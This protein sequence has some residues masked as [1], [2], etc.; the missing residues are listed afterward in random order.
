MLYQLPA[1]RFTNA[2]WP[3]FRKELKRPWE[4]HNINTVHLLIRSREKYPNLV[5]EEYLTSS[6][7]SPEILAALSF[8]HLSRLFWT[9]K[10]TATVITHPAYD[11]FGEFLA[12]SP[13]SAL[14]FWQNEINE[15]LLAPNQTKE[16]VTL[17]LLTII[18]NSNDLP[19]ENAAK[20][21]SPQFIKL[22]INSMKTLKH[23]KKEFIV[24]I[25]DEFFDALAKYFQSSVFG[26]EQTDNLKVNIMTSF[27]LSPG[28]LIIEKTSN[29]RFFHKFIGTLNSANVQQLFELFKG[30]LLDK[31]PKN[32]KNKT[33]KWLLIEKEHSVHVL[34]TLLGLKVINDAKSWREEQ[35]KFLLKL[36][37]FEKAVSKKRAS[38]ANQDS[39]D[40]P[41]KLALQI[42]QVFYNSLQIKSARLGDE[43]DILLNLVKFCNGLLAEKT[44]QLR[45]DLDAETLKSWQS[46]YLHVTTVAKNSED[47][48][49]TVIF[50]I[51]LLHMGLQLFR[52][53]EMAR[54]AIAD[55]EEC[56]KKTQKLSKTRISKAASSDEPEWIEVVVDLFMHLLS[57]NTGFLRSVVDSVFPHLCENI[58]LT[59][60][61]QILSI[62]DMR[63]GKNPLTPSN[64]VNGDEG[65]DDDDSEDDE[66]NDD[67]SNDDNDDDGDEKAD[68][69][70]N[71]DESDEESEIDE[72]EEMGDEGN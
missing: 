25:Y 58:N 60:I 61:H 42:K 57:Q 16:V 24:P 21:V 63:D 41:K 27:F 7:K 48:K 11:A 50:K 65:V 29:Y 13:K 37:F 17:K 64:G 59:A 54:T 38:I 68:S 4:K 26:T 14:K 20:F 51:L 10:S 35:L 19:A 15:I 66:E 23:Q 49:S 28:N 62:L 45:N 71:E 32:P 53:A 70:G 47:I 8:K 72:D 12:K 33:E 40:I 44:L 22:I 43:R 69:D 67:D 56:M 6:I 2:A 9:S 5:N 39:D 46:M 55:L 3:F 18:F 31:V 1:E 36:S 30:I 52:E 34:Q